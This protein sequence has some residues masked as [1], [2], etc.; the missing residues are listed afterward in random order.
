M[1][2]RV[3]E[4]KSE[5]VQSYTP[6]LVFLAQKAGFPATEND[7]RD[8]WWI[9]IHTGEGVACALGVCRERHCRCEVSALTLRS[10]EPS[11]DTLGGIGWPFILTVT[12]YP[13]L[14]AVSKVGRDV[15]YSGYCITAK[16]VNMID[17]SYLVGRLAVCSRKMLAQ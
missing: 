9:D 1:S 7:A 13:A 8:P 3:K 4:R 11:M 16:Y 10:C 5:R 14:Y 2:G 17:P 15:T 6:P 12:T